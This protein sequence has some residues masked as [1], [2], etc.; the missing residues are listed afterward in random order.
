MKREHLANRLIYHVF[1]KSIAGYRIFRDDQD[2]SRMVNL[3]QYYRTERPPTKFS[4]YMALKDKEGFF[5]K[6]C[7]GK[8]CLID[9][10]AYCIMPTHVHIVL[11]Q[12]KNNGISAFMG[13]VLNGYTRY[14]NTRTGR[15]GPLWQSRF[16]HVSVETDEQLHHLTRYVHLNPVTD[17]LVEE[18]AQWKHSSYREYIGQAERKLCTDDSGHFLSPMEYRRFVSSR[19]EYQRSLASLK[20]LFLE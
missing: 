3:M 19:K 4:A 13:N 2:Y 6:Y 16:K 5:R 18:P 9:A 11:K 15:K 14:F 20:S 12:K 17:R 10:V 1:T 7:S 8:D